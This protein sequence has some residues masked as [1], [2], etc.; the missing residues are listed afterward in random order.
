MS[1]CHVAIRVEAYKDQ[2]G[3][4][5]CYNCQQFG[6]VLANCKQPPRCMWCGGG[7]LHKECLQEGNATSILT[8]CNCKLADGKEPSPSNY[9][10][11]RHAKEQVRKR[12]SQREPKTTTGRVFTSRHT[13]PGLPFAAVLRSNRQRQPKPPSVAQARTGLPHHSG[14]NE[15]PPPLEAQPS[16]STKSVGSGSKCEQFTSDTSAGHDTAQWSR[17]RRGQNNGHHKICIKVMMQNDR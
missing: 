17:V 7:H 10:S 3:L 16:T 6:H 14:R 1:R 4:T 15:C 9:R 13:T 8:C 5:Q 11:C 2:T 12:K